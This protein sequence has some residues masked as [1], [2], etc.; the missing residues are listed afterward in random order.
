M[1]DIRSQPWESCPAATKRCTENECQDSCS[2]AG[3]YLGEDVTGLSD[4][5]FIYR[6][7]GDPC[8]GEISGEMVVRWNNPAIL[9][10]VREGAER[11]TNEFKER[12][13]A[14]LRHPETHAADPVAAIS[15]VVI[16][17]LTVK[18]RFIFWGPPVVVLTRAGRKAQKA[19][20][21]Q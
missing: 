3:P 17:Y 11:P 21:S 18:R 2:I 4:N 10:A 20:P 7:F 13:Q 1:T 15:L 8:K 12:Q 16:G 9:K 6:V 19:L 14:I 5:E